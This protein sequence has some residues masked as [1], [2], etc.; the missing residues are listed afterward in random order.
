LDDTLSS[1][2]DPAGLVDYTYGYNDYGYGY[3]NGRSPPLPAY[4]DYGGVIT[5][6]PP[7]PTFYADTPVEERPKKKT[8]TKTKTTLTASS[9]TSQRNSKKKKTAPLYDGE[10]KESQVGS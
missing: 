1:Y 2:Y 7:R 9:T 8:T 6:S 5:K 4:G 10:S 3:Q